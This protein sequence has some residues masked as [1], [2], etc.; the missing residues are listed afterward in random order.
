[1]K[2]LALALILTVFWLNSWLS[3]PA[4]I[5]SSLASSPTLTQKTK[6]SEKEFSIK[7][8]TSLTIPNEK[9][10]VKFIKV[11]EDSR[12]PKGVQCVWAGNAKVSIEI[13][14]GNKTKAIELNSTVEPTEM[15]YAG[16][17]FKF[18]QLAP[19]PTHPESSNKADYV[20]TLE[21]SKQ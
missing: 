19:Y 9:I 7:I 14:E 11:L 17:N 8:G 2:K 6:P 12:C 5:N 18:L 4:K 10:Q 15:S 3:T 20:V 1:M 21:I 13:E 16:Y